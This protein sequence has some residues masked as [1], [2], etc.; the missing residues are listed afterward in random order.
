MLFSLLQP[1]SMT[2][3]S[4]SNSAVMHVVYFRVLLDA[5]FFPTPSLRG[6][7]DGN[8]DPVNQIDLEDGVLPEDV[9]E[10]IQE[11]YWAK[12]DDIRW[13]FFREAK[14]A[15]RYS[16]LQPKLT[17]RYCLQQRPLNRHENF[18]NML[19]PLTNLP[20]EP[21]DINAFFIPSFATPPPTAAPV[22]KT[23]PGK[24][25]NK[26]KK[27]QGKVDETPDWMDAYDTESEPDSEPE[28][29][30]LGKRGRPIVSQLNMHGSVYSI[31]S[32]QLVYSA[33]WETIFGLDLEESWTRKILVGLHGERGILGHMRPARRVRVADW[34]GNVVDGGG[35]GAM[36][37]MNG[38]YVLMT[39]Y[40]L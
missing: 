13:M 25:K 27:G 33:L 39:K 12:Y 7:K 18:L 23:K 19:L 20:K 17:G 2:L 5:F 9:V 21:K 4:S 28:A 31:P 40:N 38:L 1:L 35:A 8:V 24:G 6:S 15:A 30:T 29:P 3:P 36:L 16:R 32:H 26:S 37:A 14:S 34:L 11:E 22:K 10:L